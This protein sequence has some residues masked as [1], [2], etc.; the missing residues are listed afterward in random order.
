MSTAC[1]LT[2]TIT[3][4]QGDSFTLEGDSTKVEDLYVLLAPSGTPTVDISKRH[5]KVAGSLTL[6]YIQLEGGFVLDVNVN[7][8][9]CGSQDYYCLGGSIFVSGTSSSLVAL[10]MLIKGG[11]HLYATHGAGHGGG[12]YAT[13]GATVQVTQSTFENLKAR[14]IGGAAYISGGLTTATFMQ[15]SFTG[16]CCGGSNALGGALYIKSAT[17]TLLESTFSSNSV[18]GSNRIKGGT[19]A[20]QSNAIVDITSCEFSAGLITATLLDF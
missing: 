17:A 16:N 20:L 13:N 14:Q 7:N 3:V 9:A 10:H 2:Q 19:L 15:T 18:Y 11:S 8:G 5:F 4:A 1:Q 12:L 6:R